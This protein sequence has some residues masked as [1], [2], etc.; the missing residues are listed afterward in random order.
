MSV[1]KFKFVSPGV[2]LSEVDNSQLPDTHPVVGPLVIGRTQFGPALKPVTVQS[3]SEFVETFGNPIG[4]QAGGDVWRTGNRQGPTYGVFAAQAYLRAGVGP[5]TMVRLLGKGNPNNTDTNDD[6]SQK[7]Q[8]GWATTGDI[9]GGDG[10]SYALVLVA[11]GTAPIATA[12]NAYVAAIWY[13]EDGQIELSGA[14]AGLGPTT[15]TGTYGLFEPD[16]NGEF[17]AQIKSGTSDTIVHKTAFNLNSSSRKF[18]RQVFNTNPQLVNSDVVDTSS[19]KNGEQYYWLGETFEDNILKQQDDGNIDATNRF[20]MIVA[21]GVPGGDP[22]RSDMREDYASATTG[23]F[24]SQDVSTNASSYSTNNMTNLFQII[25]RD[26]G[27]NAQTTL[28]ISIENLKASTSLDNQYGSF[29]LV[30]RR[31]TDSD[32]VVRWV[33]RFTNL[34]LNPASEQYIGLVIGDKYLEYDETQ[35]RLRE[36]GQ[37]NNNS[38]YI[39]VNIAEDVDNGQTNPVFLPF[40][41]IGPQIPATVTMEQSGTAVTVAD[42]KTSMIV[43]SSLGANERSSTTYGYDGGVYVSHTASIQW[44]QVTV[45]ISG[46]DGALANTKDAY[47]GAQSATRVSSNGSISYDRGWGDLLRAF[48][49]GMVGTLTPAW[50]V[51]LDDLVT[52]SNNAYWQSG[53]RA[54]GTSATAVGGTYESILDA[55]YDNFTSPLYGGFDGLNIKEIEPFRNSAMTTGGTPDTE[56]NNY[57]VNTIQQAL[58]SVSDPEAV[59]FNLLAVPGITNT[60]LT[61]QMIDVCEDRADALAVI[62]LSDVYTPFTENTESFKDRITVP[63]T[64]VATLRTRGLNSSYACTYYPWVQIRDTINSRLLWAPPSVIALGVMAGSE[65]AS[66]LW[67]APAGFNRGGLTEGSAGIPVTGVTYKL[68]SKERDTLY[69]ANVNPIA[70]FPSEGIVVFGQKTLQVT[71]SAL[72]RI[73]V[74]RLMI[75]IKKEVSRISSGLL[76]DQNVSVTWNRFLNQVNP[77]L[78]SI[79]SDLGLTEFRVIL[80]ETTT[81]PDLV[82]QNIMY[83]KIFLKPARSIEFIAVD[84]VITRSGASFDD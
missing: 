6:P 22:V 64:T 17:V 43:S 83:A 58:H 75:Y 84:F 36:Y 21:L 8:A 67:F 5:V 1:K 44:P 3:F 74:R 37:Y 24:F 81:T 23:W 38:K 77:F 42:S 30:V 40:G 65:A 52:G 45:R 72:D 29:D 62:D 56:F 50:K 16:S 25:A 48:P 4:G 54:A 20:A 82:D 39:R 33:E 63:N 55:G 46:S 51:S 10:G 31:A 13:M 80:D 57:A 78:N 32:N 66:K 49:A 28:K 73:N 71:R 68:T 27:E 60:K 26:A 11:S 61:Q 12:Q 15:T 19:L 69:T 47:F 35:Q 59:E 9:A 79:Q 7:G 53:S 41:V 76:F 2:F 14:L 70:S 18:I 34:N